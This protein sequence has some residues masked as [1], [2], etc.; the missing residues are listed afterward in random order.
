MYILDNLTWQKRCVVFFCCYLCGFFYMQTN[1]KN[2]S[3]K[4]CDEK[5][6]KMNKQIISKQN[7]DRNDKDTSNL[8]D[9]YLEQRTT[10]GK[11]TALRNNLLLKIPLVLEYV[12]NSSDSFVCSSLSFAVAKS[13]PLKECNISDIN[14]SDS[15]AILQ[16]GTTKS[17]ERSKKLTSHL[18]AFNQLIP[19]DTLQYSESLSSNNQLSAFQTENNLQ[20]SYREEVMK[21]ARLIC[22]QSDN[23]LNKWKYVEDK[24]KT[25]VS[26]YHQEE[27]KR[28]SKKNTLKLDIYGNNKMINNHAFYSSAK[29]TNVGSI[30][31]CSGTTFQHKHDDVKYL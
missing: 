10:I 1:D 27:K 3:L 9:L 6:L 16:Y 14:L 11:T 24:I 29:V 19:T 5:Y 23:N 17:H 25:V 26:K 21:E 13:A 12:S 22:N 7:V 31:Y 20:G 18:S 28:T 4:D 8:D 30:V 15:N 2:T